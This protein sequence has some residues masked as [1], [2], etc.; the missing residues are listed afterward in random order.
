[1]EHFAEIVDG[2]LLST[3]FT[4]RFILDIWQGFEYVSAKYLS[5]EL[6]ETGCRLALKLGCWWTLKPSIVVSVAFL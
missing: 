4:E 2:F 1:M 3:I 5:T 6:C